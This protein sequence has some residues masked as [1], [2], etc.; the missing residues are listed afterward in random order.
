MKYNLI[1]MN[2]KKNKVFNLVIIHGGIKLFPDINI[3]YRTIY[4]H[5]I[6]YRDTCSFFFVFFFM[7]S[8]D[9]MKK[10]KIEDLF[11]TIIELHGVDKIM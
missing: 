8:H 3:S 9:K 11:Y 7:T 5:I 6:N 1:G 2:R 4:F 10:K